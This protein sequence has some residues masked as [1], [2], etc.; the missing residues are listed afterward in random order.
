METVLTMRI[1]ARAIFRLALLCMVIPCMFGCPSSKVYPSIEIGLKSGISISC[2]YFV[3]KVYAGSVEVPL[4]KFQTDTVCQWNNENIEQYGGKKLAIELQFDSLIN[5]ANGIALDTVFVEQDYNIMY[6]IYI[7]TQ[8][9]SIPTIDKRV[10]LNDGL[11]DTV[12]LSRFQSN[13]RPAL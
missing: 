3:P 7:G 4:A 1:F 6:S 9:E 10:P 5:G 2:Q 8:P 12:Y 13:I 11:G